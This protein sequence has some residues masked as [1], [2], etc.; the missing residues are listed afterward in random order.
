MLAT[1]DGALDSQATLVALEQVAPRA[2]VLHLESGQE[3]L[4]Y[5]FGT[6]E[7]RGRRSGQPGLVLLTFELHGISGLC[8]LDL[9]RAH[10]ST[11][12]VPVVLLG[13][14]SDIRRYRR[15]DQFDADAYIVQPCDFQRR[16]LVM[17]GCVGH[18][19]PWALRPGWHVTTSHR[20]SYAERL[21]FP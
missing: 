15:N 13:L 18:W 1:P 21:G 10:P 14:D 20:R 8:V 16:C 19:L 7:Y 3:A 4:E 12:R 17:R 6:G 11:N 2:T 9:M 5:V